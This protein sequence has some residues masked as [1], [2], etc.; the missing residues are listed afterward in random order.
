M[1]VLEAPPGWNEFRLSARPPQKKD[2][3]GSLMFERNP[4][5]AELGKPAK[6]REPLLDFWILPDV[7]GTQEPWWYFEA[8]RRIDPRV[9]WIDITMRMPL[10]G[11]PSDNSL[12]Q[13][14]VRNRPKYGLRSWF[15]KQV[16]Q[17]RNTRRDTVMAMLSPAQIAANTTRGTTPGL[18]DHI[19][20]EAGG[21]V[22]HP[23]GRKGQGVRRGPRKKAKLNISDNEADDE[24]S[25]AEDDSDGVSDREHL[26]SWAK[27]VIPRVKP[28]KSMAR[29]SKLENTADWKWVGGVL[30]DGQGLGKSKPLGYK[31]QSE[32]GAQNGGGKKRKAEVEEK[33]GPELPRKKRVLDWLTA[34]P[35]G[36]GSFQLPRNLVQT[37]LRETVTH[38]P[39]DKPHH[40]YDWHS[41]E[42]AVPYNTTSYVSQR[43]IRFWKPADFSPKQTNFFQELEW[44]SKPTLG[45]QS[46][47]GGDQC[48][49]NSHFIAASTFGG[50]AELGPID[51]NKVANAELNRKRKRDEDCAWDEDGNRTIKKAKYTG[52]RDME[53]RPLQVESDAEFSHPSSRPAFKEP[54]MVV[55][56]PAP[57]NKRKRGRKDSI[58][59][60]EGE[61]LEPKESES[62]VDQAIDWHYPPVIPAQG[63]QSDSRSSPRY[64]PYKCSEMKSSQKDPSILI[65]PLL[66]A[67]DGLRRAE[68]ES[69]MSLDQSHQI[70]RLP[71][72]DFMKQVLAGFAFEWQE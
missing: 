64:I 38:I 16:H 18:I 48:Q 71:L 6:H 46:Y 9:R 49:Y 20:G 3:D 69:H 15:P 13:D 2:A 29:R 35:L 26:D 45:V 55:L 58:V 14:G 53:S 12:N 72:M 42:Q 70:H 67:R 36:P 60:F 37:Q 27:P 22:P 52:A 17:A 62:A 47:D 30:Y 25:E 68:A 24:E 33:Q 57:S 8:I 39:N 59:S 28:R 44:D 19:L 32:T 54:V 51:G 11:R 31:Q 23:A 56:P 43:Q 40:R 34:T 21:R 65:C 1:Y 50:T 5:P 66:S 41:I 10:E 7:I 61:V 63:R 4:R